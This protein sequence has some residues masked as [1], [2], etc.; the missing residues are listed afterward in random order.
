[1]LLLKNASIYE[2]MQKMGHFLNLG[3]YSYEFTLLFLAKTYATLSNTVLIN[4]SSI[5]LPLSDLHIVIY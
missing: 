1:M 2:A 4:E 5:G 3:V